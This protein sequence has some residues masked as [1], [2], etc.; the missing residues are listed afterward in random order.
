MPQINSQSSMIGTHTIKS[1]ITQ[2]MGIQNAKSN[3]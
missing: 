1:N 2:E 3:F